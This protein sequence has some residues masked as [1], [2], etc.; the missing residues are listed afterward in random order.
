MAVALTIVCVPLGGMIGGLVA[1]V[2]LPAFG[3]RALFVLGGA[4]P[5]AMAAI[6]LW[7][8]PESPRFMARRPERF[9]DLARICSDPFRT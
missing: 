5:L 4:A 9:A 6:L 3:W 8:L 7:A 1:A 2:V